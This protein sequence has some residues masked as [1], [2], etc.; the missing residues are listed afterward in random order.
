MNRWIILHLPS[1]HFCPFVS[2]LIHHHHFLDRSSSPWFH[3]SISFLLTS[4]SRASWYLPT[5]TATWLT[6]ERFL[7]SAWGNTLTWWS[8]VFRTAFSGPECRSARVCH[9]RKV[10]TNPRGSWPYLSVWN[11]MLLI[12]SLCPFHCI[13]GL[14]DHFFREEYCQYHM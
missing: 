2:R 4:V 5:P 9:T 8:T 13:V 11:F 12:W 3:R 10:A 6:S 14:A 7:W 1:A